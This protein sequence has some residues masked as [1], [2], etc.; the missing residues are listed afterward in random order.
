MILMLFG[1]M[2]SESSGIE[3]CFRNH[4]RSNSYHIRI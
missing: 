4:W 3:W 1:N 2:V